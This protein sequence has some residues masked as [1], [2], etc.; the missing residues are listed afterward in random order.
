M[1][2]QDGDPTTVV[3][4]GEGTTPVPVSLSFINNEFVEPSTGEFI[5]RS[6][7]PR[8][9]PL[10]CSVHLPLRASQLTL[11][12]CRTWSARGRAR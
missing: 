12:R 4:E 8:L 3:Q 9:P 7:A 6:S 5:V 11:L 10:L 1:T 2:V